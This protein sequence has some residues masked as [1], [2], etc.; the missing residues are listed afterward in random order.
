MATAFVPWMT[1]TIRMLLFLLLQA[2]LAT[3]A[4]PIPVMTKSKPMVVLVQE[5]QKVLIVPISASLQAM[6]SSP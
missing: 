4:M 6:D 5:H 2:L 3:M 1:V